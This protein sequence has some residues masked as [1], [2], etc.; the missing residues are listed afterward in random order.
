MIEILGDRR[1]IEAA[2]RACRSACRARRGR[3][4]SACRAGARGSC[5]WRRRRCAGRRAPARAA[6][7]ASPCPSRRAAGRP[8]WRSACAQRSGWRTA[9]ATPTMPPRLA[10]TKVTGVVQPQPSSHAATRSARPATEM[11]S[12]S[13]GSSKPR[14]VDP[15]PGQHGQ[16]TVCFAGSIRSGAHSAGHHAA[17]GSSPS[18]LAVAERKRRRGDA[19]DDHDDRRGAELGPVDPAAELHVLERRAPRW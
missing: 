14:H 18:R 11:A 3:D 17:R 1:P 2:A 5:R 10:P 6:G 9:N 8:R 12:A 13:R 7:A 4:R 15:L 19:A 16:S